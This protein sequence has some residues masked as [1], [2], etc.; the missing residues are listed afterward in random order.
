MGALQISQTKWCIQ[1]KANERCFHMWLQCFADYLATETDTNKNLMALTHLVNPPHSKLEGNPRTS[2]LYAG[3]STDEQAVTYLLRQLSTGL[4]S[5]ILILLLAVLCPWPMC[6]R[7]P[8]S[9]WSTLWKFC[10]VHYLHHP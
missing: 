8:C 9:F 3:S 6:L 1:V 10:Q 7:H 5:V 4:L 2:L